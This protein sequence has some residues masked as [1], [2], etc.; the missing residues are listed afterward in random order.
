MNVLHMGGSRN[1]NMPILKSSNAQ[2]GEG[3][4]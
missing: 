2:G 1:L 3:G 4:C